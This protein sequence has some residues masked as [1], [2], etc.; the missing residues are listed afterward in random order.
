MQELVQGVKFRYSQF[1]YTNLLANLGSLEYYMF[2][3][4]VQYILN[5]EL[6]RQLRET[7][8]ILKLGQ[9]KLDIFKILRKPTIGFSGVETTLVPKMLELIAQGD[10]LAAQA[11]VEPT[12]YTSQPP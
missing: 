12:P 11:S 7:C 1:V 2:L 5:C 9:M 8:N 4:Y 10:N 3:R 6:G